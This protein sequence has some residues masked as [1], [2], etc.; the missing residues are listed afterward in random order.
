MVRFE[1]SQHWLGIGNYI[2]Q[3]TID[4]II[5]FHDIFSSNLY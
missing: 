1:I 5:F 4:V 3:E 2:L